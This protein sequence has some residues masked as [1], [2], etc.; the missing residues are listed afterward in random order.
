[1]ESRERNKSF[2][3]GFLVYLTDE[4]HL[5]LKLLS[6]YEKKPM[7]AIVRDALRNH[8]DLF[9]ESSKVSQ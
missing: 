8:L 6:A 2:P 7:T 4:D 1:M 5:R 3:Q 9:A